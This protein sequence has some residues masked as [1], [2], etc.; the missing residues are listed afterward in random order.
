MELVVEQDTHQETRE[1]GPHDEEDN[2]R[3]KHAG[4]LLLHMLRHT[5]RNPPLEI[6]LDVSRVEVHRPGQGVWRSEGHFSPIQVK[7]LSYIYT[8]RNYHEICYRVH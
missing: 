5:V 1:Q 6:H 3:P 8:K 2:D 7:L 4:D